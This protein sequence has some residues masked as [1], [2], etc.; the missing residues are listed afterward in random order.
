MYYA[1]RRSRFGAQYQL[2]LYFGENI[3]L[4]IVSS[5]TNSLN[6]YLID[7]FVASKELCDLIKFN[8]PLA[9]LEAC[10]L[11]LRCFLR[12]L[13]LYCLLTRRDMQKLPN[14]EPYF[15]TQID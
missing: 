4:H 12:K 10:A 7:F 14:K 8:S 9:F 15:F 1:I 11:F 13:F 2:G 6:R 3:V 5:N